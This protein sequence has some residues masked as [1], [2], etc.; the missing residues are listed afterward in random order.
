MMPAMSLLRPAREADLPGIFAIYDHEARHGIATCDTEPRS[1]EERLIWWRAHDAADYPVLVAEDATTPGAIAAWGALS[2]WSP[3]PA[4]D[5]TCEDTV[6]VA[7][8]H[9]GRGLG[10][11]LLEELIRLARARGRALIIARIVE[12]N[13][14][15]RAVH[16]RCGFETLGIMPGAAEKFGRVLDVRILGLRLRP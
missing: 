10:R 13:P 1:P 9:Q 12:G 11:A 6:Y 3:R 4:Y 14:V 5:R 7:G 8:A 15:S 2:R 16:E